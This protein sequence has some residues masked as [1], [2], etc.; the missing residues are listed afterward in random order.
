VR[1][2]P[3]TNSVTARI[4]VGGNPEDVV[5]AAGAAWV[6]NENGTVSRIDPA[7]NAVTARIRVGADPDN[8]VFCR[9]R[10]WVSS[11]RGPR[12]Y[13][14]NPATN[15]AA[16]RVRVGTGTVGLACSRALWVANYDTGQV[17]KIDLRRRRV[18]RRIDVGVQPREV[19]LGAG[20]LWVSNQGSGTV[21]RIRP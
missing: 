21:S 17:L 18:L 2:D 14:L 19:E 7:T 16:A 6:P 13:V 8:A 15:A 3:S 1:I 5:L 11:L 20:A 9:G 4:A 12:L 10:L